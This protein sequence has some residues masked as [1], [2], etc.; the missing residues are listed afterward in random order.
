MRPRMNSSLSP[1]FH[2]LDEYTFQDL[3]CD[4]FARQPG[5]ATCDP[6]GTRGQKQRGIDLLA[7]RTGGDGIEVGSVSATGISLQRR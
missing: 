1:P 6:Y 2:E 7:R 3:C 5:I 4:V